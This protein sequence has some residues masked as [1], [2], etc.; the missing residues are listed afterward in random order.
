VEEERINTNLNSLLHPCNNTEPNEPENQQVL[1]TSEQT[2]KQTDSI[3][4]K[5]INLKSITH[6]TEKLTYSQIAITERRSLLKTWMASVIGT[7]IAFALVSGIKDLR[8][9]VT[10]SMSAGSIAFVVSALSNS[11]GNK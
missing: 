2:D 5:Q 6:S 1:D 3:K 8:A 4:L 10:T 9:L 7:A 11:S